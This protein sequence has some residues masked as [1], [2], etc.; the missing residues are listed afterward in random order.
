[1]ARIGKKQAM[2]NTAICN[3]ITLLDQYNN[4]A[5]TK[6]TLEL[7]YKNVRN[8]VWHLDEKYQAEFRTYPSI[9]KVVAI[10]E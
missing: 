6:D 2:V 4:N 7:C 3:I 9:K 8:M 1:M 10:I 5:I